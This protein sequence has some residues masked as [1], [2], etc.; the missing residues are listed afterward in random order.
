MWQYCQHPGTAPRKDAVVDGDGVVE[1]TRGV[2]VCRYHLR[3]LYPSSRC[4]VST[5]G[6]G[7]LVA[8]CALIHHCTYLYERI[9]IY[10]A[11]KYV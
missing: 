4:V 5:T 3:H 2:W 11:I 1:A 6:E 10:N 9:F 8:V 7:N